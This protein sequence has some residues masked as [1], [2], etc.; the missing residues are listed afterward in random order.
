[1]NLSRTLSIEEKL[2]I[3]RAMK[4]EFNSSGHW[5]ECPNG[6]PYTIGECGGA[7]QLSRCPDCHEQIGGG[8][9]QL[10][11]GNRINSEFGSMY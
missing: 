4:S 7:M 1:M 9:H 10:T 2:E 6:H 11:S 8:G 3:H 5:Y